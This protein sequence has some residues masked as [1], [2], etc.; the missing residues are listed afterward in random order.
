MSLRYL[1]LPVG[2]DSTQLR[3]DKFKFLGTFQQRGRDEMGFVN[4]FDIRVAPFQISHR[5]GRDPGRTAG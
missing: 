1:S 2:A 4:T 3:D 5:G